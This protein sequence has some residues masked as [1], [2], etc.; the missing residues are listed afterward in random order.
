MSIVAATDTV[1]HPKTIPYK[2][3]GIGA[4][5]YGVTMGNAGGFVSKVRHAFVDQGIKTGGNERQWDLLSR[6]GT[7]PQARGVAPAQLSLWS[8]WLSKGG[9]IPKGLDPQ[10][11]YN[12]LDWSY[13]EIGRHDQHKTSFLQDVLSSPITTVVLGVA[14]GGVYAAAAAL[15][16]QLAV[17]A[18]AKSLGPTAPEPVSV[19]GAAPPGSPEANFTLGGAP[20]PAAAAGAPTPILGGAKTTGGAAQLGVSGMGF[21]GATRTAKYGGDGGRAATNA[22]TILGA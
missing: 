17:G 22:P 5:N 16:T 13:R 10:I 18:I 21:G 1:F 4:L 8:S 3:P 19:A 7:T 6:W 14:T 2:Y 9:A 12:A 20:R 15:A 11:P